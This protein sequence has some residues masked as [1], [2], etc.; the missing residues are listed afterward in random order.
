MHSKYLV[1]TTANF[2]RLIREPGRRYFRLFKWHS[3]W[4]NA[5]ASFSQKDQGA[6]QTLLEVAKWSLLGFYFFLEMWTIVSCNLTSP[7]RGP[8][9]G[10]L[11][12]TNAMGVTDFAWGAPLQ[13]E[14]NR[15][16]F[17]GLVSSIL[18][19]VVSLLFAASSTGAPTKAEKQG[20]AAKNGKAAVV[21]SRAAIVAQL[22]IDSCD[23]FTP[24]VAIGVI[25][26]GPLIVGTASVLSSSIAGR[27]IWNR[28]QQASRKT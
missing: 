17:Y 18:L 7:P 19:S 8:A 4:N 26:A 14:A 6:I 11:S 24:G 23:I 3:C 1:S 21:P 16:W 27:Q 20:K 25:F 28:V 2:A 22:M 10:C 5:Y 13:F 15:C 12:Q 9:D